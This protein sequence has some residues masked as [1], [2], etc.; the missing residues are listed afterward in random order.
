[1]YFSLLFDK[2][3]LT[4]DEVRRALRLSRAEIESDFEQASLITDIAE[5]YLDGPELIQEF[6]EAARALDRA[7]EIRI[8]P[9]AV[10]GAGHRRARHG[11]GWQRGRGAQRVLPALP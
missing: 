2:R 5:D 1:M 6:V 9:A 8:W 7:G 3:E 11:R 10:S 4:T